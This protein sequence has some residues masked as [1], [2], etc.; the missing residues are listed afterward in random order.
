MGVVVTAGG[1]VG[2]V[3]PLATKLMRELEFRVSPEVERLVLD[4][5]G[6]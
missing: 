5:A 4:L 3:A 1:L 6:E 2:A